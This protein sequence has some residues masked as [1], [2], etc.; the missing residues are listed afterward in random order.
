MDD[1]F[2]PPGE[3][4]VG[5]SPRLRDMRRTV[6]AIAAAVVVAGVAIGFTA[7]GSISGAVMGAVGVILLAA[8]AFVIVGRNYDS[9]GYAERAEDLLVTHG[10]MFRRLVVVPYGRMQ[11]VD[12]TAG[13][14]ER[15]FGIATLR[16]HTAAAGT[17]ARI[18]GLTPPEATRLRDRLAALGE[19]QSA[20]L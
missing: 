8:A 19:S 11:L 7:A 12:V 15:K 3:R 18:H 1:A 6:L 13:P 16:L 17:D 9:W 10:V 5:V 4:W 2:A 20:G 14:L